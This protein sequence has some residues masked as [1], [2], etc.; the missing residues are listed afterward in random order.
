MV[1]RGCEAYSTAWMRWVGG[2]FA[3]WGLGCRKE[4]LPQHG[5]PLPEEWAKADPHQ[6]R[7]PEQL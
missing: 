7:V 3:L 2:T 4:Q 1:A 5:P 6:A